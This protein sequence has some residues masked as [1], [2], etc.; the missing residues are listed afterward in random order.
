M[1][2]K[3]GITDVP[4]EVT[5]ETDESP[6]DIQAK[7]R[8][9]LAAPDGLFSLNDPKGRTILVPAHTIAYLD[10]GQP[11]ARPVGFGIA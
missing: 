1:E 3:I 2:I 4:R 7:L 6:E 9:A 8:S 5:I 11:N 10:L